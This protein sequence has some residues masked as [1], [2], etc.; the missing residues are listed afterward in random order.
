[1][2]NL[3]VRCAELGEKL[4]GLPGAEEKT[5]T[6]ALAVLEEQGLYAFFLFLHAKAKDGAAI[7]RAC[8]AFLE[9]TP[10]SGPLLGNKDEDLPDRLRALGQDLD[11]LLFARDLLHQALVYARYHLKARGKKD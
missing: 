6:S 4:A 7:S 10:Q 1:M 8:A 5:I 3:D 11:K 2:E 9:R